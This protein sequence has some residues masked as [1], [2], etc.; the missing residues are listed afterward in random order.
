MASKL[1]K[2]EQLM[3]AEHD[4]TLYTERIHETLVRINELKERLELAVSVELLQELRGHELNLGYY[5][6]SKRL[7]EN[8]INQLKGEM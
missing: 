5:S 4:L 3:L 6:S 1:N 7:A 8:K 2:E